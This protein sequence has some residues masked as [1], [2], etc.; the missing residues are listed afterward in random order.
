MFPLNDALFATAL[1][2][3]I[4]VRTASP[5]RAGPLLHALAVCAGVAAGHQLMFALG[6]PALALL[7]YAPG[8]EYLRGAPGR[9]WS[10]VA[11]SAVP[12][13][14]AYALIPLAASRSPYLSW[15]T[16][17][18]GS[19]F[20][21][22]VTRGDYGGLLRPSRHPSTDSGW[23]RVAAFWELIF[24]SAGIVVVFGAIVGVA[25]RLR[26]DGSVGGALLL[27]V[28]VA[29]PVFAWLNALPVT[30]IGRLAYFER[31]TTMCGVA[32]AL[33]F[34]CGV[35]LARAWLPRGRPGSW[36]LAAGLLSWA[37]LRAYDTRDV[38]LH[39]D[40]SGIDFAHALLLSTPDRSVVLLSGDQPID[41]ELYVCGVERLCGERIALAPGMLALP[42]KMAQVRARHP[43]L[44]IPWTDGPALARTHLLVGAIRDRP[45][46]LFPDL[47]AKDPL[48]ASLDTDDEGFLLRVRRT[49]EPPP[50][51]QGGGR[52]TSR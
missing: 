46:Y 1:A 17:H 10:L 47:I 7:V 21:H 24:V 6:L 39:A 9:A 18:D 37:A 12:V 44:D 16:V 35:Q 41:S 31:F 50:P 34:G 11:A 43:D 29:G 2:L 25:A 5:A 13:V 3:A 40:R 15:G 19:S 22:L 23:T 36:A 14:L 42:W 51:D 32:V 30:A 38:D 27:A 33:A 45:V 26:R 8:R 52:S 20:V 48:L 28:L 4:G 49:A